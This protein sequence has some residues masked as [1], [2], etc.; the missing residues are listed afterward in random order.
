MCSTCA[1]HVHNCQADRQLWKRRKSNKGWTC[2]AVSSPIYEM[3]SL[4]GYSSRVPVEVDGA[5]DWNTLG[6]MLA[7]ELLGQ[8]SRGSE[9]KSFCTCTASVDSALNIY[10]CHRFEITVGL[11]RCTPPP[12]PPPPTAPFQSPPVSAPSLQISRMGKLPE[13]QCDHKV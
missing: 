10:K 12:P 7:A 9:S 5:M 11:Y 8:V 1:V 3:C 2:P 13:L 4:Y 6:K